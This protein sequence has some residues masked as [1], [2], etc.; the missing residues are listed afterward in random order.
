MLNAAEKSLLPT[1]AD[2]HF[3]KRH[4]Y[5]VSKKIFSDPEMGALVHYCP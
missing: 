3:Y 4:G 5:F 1:E 2:V